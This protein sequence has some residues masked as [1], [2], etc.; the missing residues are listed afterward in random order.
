MESSAS[1]PRAAPLKPVKSNI[2]HKRPKTIIKSM[3]IARTLKTSI[4][5]LGPKKLIRLG[6]TLR[7][8][9]TSIEPT[10]PTHL[11]KTTIIAQMKNYRLT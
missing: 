3:K 2:K 11:L 9:L 7:H 4:Y 6:Q 8:H 10:L 1:S 5:L